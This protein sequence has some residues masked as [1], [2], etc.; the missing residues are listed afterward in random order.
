MWD[1][2]FTSSRKKKK[3]KTKKNKNDSAA[4]A[5]VVIDLYPKI[6]FFK[7]LCQLWKKLTLYLG[8]I[9]LAKNYATN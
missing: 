6:S 9:Y 8:I 7:I 2:R 1:L 5:D 4:T 3:T